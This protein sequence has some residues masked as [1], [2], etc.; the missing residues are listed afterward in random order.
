MIPV[1]YLWLTVIAVFAII[2]LARG[3]WRE[4]GVTAILLLS[5]FA[6][7]L[8]ERV[9]LDTVSNSLPQ[10]T[11]GAPSGMVTAIY[12][13][14]IMIFVTFIAYQGVTLEFPVR[15]QKGLFKWI[16]GYLGGLANGYL[17]VGT[18]W[19]VISDA[20]Y[21][22]INVPMGTSGTKV[23]ISTNLT[24]LH[25]EIIKYLPVTLMNSSSTFGYVF[26]GVGMLLLLA[27]ILK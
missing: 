6:L 24:S 23:A 27:I 25:G 21:L 14:S 26:L 22:G 16:F 18:I 19:N 1:E 10:L 9:I 11:S 15:K 4:L 8:G 7:N 20:K 2:G 5:L 12:Y 3:L 13:S 17:V